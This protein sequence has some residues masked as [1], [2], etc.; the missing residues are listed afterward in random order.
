MSGAETKRRGSF[1]KMELVAAVQKDPEAFV[2]DVV[3]VSVPQVASFIL[4]K[5]LGG[6]NFPGIAG[7]GSFSMRYS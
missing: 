5:S 6:F 2:K 4:P 1:S 7:G 3:A